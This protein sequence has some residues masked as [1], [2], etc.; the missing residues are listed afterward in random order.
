M[1]VWWI[2][3]GKMSL[4]AHNILFG[5]KL[6]GGGRQ[7]LFE[8]Q[9]DLARAIIKEHIAFKRRPEP[10]VRAFLN[11]ALKPA[12]DPYSRP[13]S[14]NL[15][16]AIWAAVTNRAK[17]SEVEDI[18][19][20]LEKALSDLKDSSKFERP[21]DSQQDWESLLETARAARHHF[22]VTPTPA[23]TITDE[24][25]NVLSQILCERLYEAVEQNTQDVFYEFY[26]PEENAAEHMLK[27]LGKD[28]AAKCGSEKEA[29]ELIKNA[30]KSA[31]KKEW[32]LSISCGEIVGFTPPTVVFEP[33]K[34]GERS[35]YV[36]FYHSKKD[37][38]GRT[39]SV[40]RMDDETLSRW[41]TNVYMPLVDRKPGFQ[42]RPVSYPVPENL[43][44]SPNKP[45]SMKR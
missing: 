25:A 41:Y 4:E 5:E 36:L 17:P 34:K 38:A 32:G 45:G 30:Q 9:A 8:S 19:R 44:E 20:R 39:V 24:A 35:G 31:E 15:H 27:E 37:S 12:N 6:R 42:T 10:T 22:I 33:T 14:P 1:L 28:L 29:I 43:P 40:A 21:S 2:E 11:Q 23:E 16:D 13:V 7:P 18:L 3:G 26:I